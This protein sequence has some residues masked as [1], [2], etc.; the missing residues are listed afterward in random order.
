MAKQYYLP[1]KDADKA[2]WLQN[3]ANKLPAYAAKYLISSNEVY[4]M[5]NSAA[6]FSYWL[7]YQS[8]YEEFVKK[9]TQYKN[10][11]RDGVPA[12]AVIAMVPVPPTIPAQLQPVDPGIFTRATALANVIKS[13]QIYSAADGLDLGIEGAVSRPDVASM[14]PSISVRLIAGGYPEIVWSKNGMDGIDIYKDTGSGWQLLGFDPHPNYTDK[15]TLPPIGQSAIWHYK[16]IYRMD[17]DQVGQWSD[18]VTI[19]VAGTV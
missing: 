16:C 5:Q 3:F 10:E 2:L 4:D 11:M 7:N 17:D 13:R 18:T 8:Q 14:K 19:T 1:R 9:I 6:V 12:G 15:S